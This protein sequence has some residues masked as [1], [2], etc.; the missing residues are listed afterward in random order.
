MVAVTPTVGPG[1]LKEKGSD[2]LKLGRPFRYAILGLVG[3]FFIIPIL[4]SARYSFLGNNNTYTISAYTGLFGTHEFWTTLFLSVKI[5]VGTVFLTLF[6]LIPTVIWVN[7]RLPHLRRVFEAISL[8]PL[9]VPS[10]VITLGVITSFKHLPNIIIGTPV[11]LSLEYV[12]LALPYSYRTFDSAVQA[13]DLKTLVEAGQSLGSGWG[14]LLRFVLLPNLRAGLFGAAVL[15][16]AY[17][18]G[19]FAVASLLSFTTFPV[20]LVQVGQTAASQAVA[21]SLIALLFTWI[22]LAVIVIIFAQR[23]SRSTVED[24]VDPLEA[25]VTL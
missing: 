4:A 5:G 2:V 11:I 25:G 15:T 20:F 23:R 12:V 8:L 16:F 7:L 19:E 10:V 17:C 3:V 21:L 22:P 18:I 1:V 13:L 24:A 9:V 14:K 6:L